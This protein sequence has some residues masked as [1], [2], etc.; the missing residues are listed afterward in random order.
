M[1]VD[2]A[3]V[4]AESEV[5]AALGIGPTGFDPATRGAQMNVL[6]GDNM[7]IYCQA[8]CVTK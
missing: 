6:G 3:T 5:R 4:Q 7:A 8:T 2:S 1:G